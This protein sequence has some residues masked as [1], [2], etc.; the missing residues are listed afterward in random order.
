MDTNTNNATEFLAKKFSQIERLT[1]NI[2]GFGV[3]YAKPMTFAEKLQMKGIHEE[4]N[5]RKQ[6]LKMCKVITDRT[7]DEDGNKVFLNYDN[8]QAHVALADSCD[9]DDVTEIFTQVVGVS[10]G[11]DEVEE[12]AGKSSPAD[13]DS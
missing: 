2:K 7:I 8:K 12:V 6:A 4:K 10:E 11:D 1:V 3:C 5:E 9:G 13:T